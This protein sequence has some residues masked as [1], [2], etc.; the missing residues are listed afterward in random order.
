MTVFAEPGDILAQ[1]VQ[2]G[3]DRRMIL[4]D[5]K[6]RRGPEVSLCVRVC[7]DSLTVFRDEVLCGIDRQLTCRK[8]EMPAIG[9]GVD[10]VFVYEPLAILGNRQIGDFLQWQ[11]PGQVQLNRTVGNQ[12]SAVCDGAEIPRGILTVAKVDQISKTKTAKLTVGAAE[13]PVTR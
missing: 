10:T 8:D 1:P 13:P 5:Q 6:N 7:W 11:E 4:V 3:A 2:F 9:D 12:I